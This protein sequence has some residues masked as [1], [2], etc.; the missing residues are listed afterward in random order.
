MVTEKEIIEAIEKMKEANEMLEEANATL[1]RGFN[2]IGPNGSG[3][4]ERDKLL[5]KYN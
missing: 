2:E 1:Q 4:R 5:R 3:L